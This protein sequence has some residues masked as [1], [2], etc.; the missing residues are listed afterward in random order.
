VD[1]FIAFTITLAVVAFVFGL[2]RFIAFAGDDKS[3]TSGKTM[4]LW[5]LL[6]LLCI[7]SVWGL[8]EVVFKTFFG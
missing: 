8:V 6:A 3:R 2:V 5:G 4:M 1:S 7:V